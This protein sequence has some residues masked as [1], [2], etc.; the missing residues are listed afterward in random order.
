MRIIELKH[1]LTEH[2]L[3]ADI[4]LAVKIKTRVWTIKKIIVVGGV[5]GG[6]LNTVIL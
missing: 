5:C 4:L 2:L 1:S 3:A 6:T